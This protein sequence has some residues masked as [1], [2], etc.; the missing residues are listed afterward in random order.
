MPIKVLDD[1][2][3]GTDATVICGVD[4]LT[5]LAV[6]GIRRTTSLLPT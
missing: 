5:Q 4:Y 2:G 6:T 1:T 3:V